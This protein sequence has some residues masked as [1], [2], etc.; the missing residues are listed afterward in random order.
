L[1]RSGEIAFGKPRFMDCFA[2]R[3]NQNDSARDKNNVE[4]VLKVESGCVFELR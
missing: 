4:K 3:F 1:E 2:S